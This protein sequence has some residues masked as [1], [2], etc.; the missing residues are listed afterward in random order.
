[1]KAVRMSAMDMTLCSRG[2]GLCKDSLVDTNWLG[3]FS[4]TSLI[5]L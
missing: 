3:N 1:M 2:K 4:L 5:S